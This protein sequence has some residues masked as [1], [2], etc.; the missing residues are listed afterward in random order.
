VVE[1]ASPVLSP[2]AASIGYFGA[3]LNVFLILGYFLLSW[4]AV[5][6]RD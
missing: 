1:T 3:G 6:E 2:G 4:R 5:R